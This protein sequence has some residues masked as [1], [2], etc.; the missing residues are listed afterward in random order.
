MR[1]LGKTFRPLLLTLVAGSLVVTGCGDSKRNDNGTS[2]TFFGWFN[3][4]NG[5]A[6]PAPNVVTP[7]ADDETSA[8]TENQGRSGL[9]FLAAGLQNNLSGQAIRGSRMVHEYFVPR[10]TASVPR[11]SVG[12]PIFLAANRAPSDNNGIGG[13]SSLP[14]GLGSQ[15]PGSSTQPVP[16]GT[17]GYVNVPVVT[18]DVRSFLV[19]NRS[20]FPEP[21]YSMLVRSHAVG[22]TT[23]G[24][25]ITSN[26]IEL[27]VTWTPDVLIVTPDASTSSLEGDT[28]LSGFEDEGTEVDSE[29]DEVIFQ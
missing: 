29:D 7:L 6:V 3:L 28:S 9:V 15:Q 12:M 4:V 26:A 2:F 18:A 22:F 19:L 10:A 14:D 5:A 24:E 1:L 8:P 11:T 27:E 23:A 13:D 20:Q 17:V 25:E 16:F 21:P